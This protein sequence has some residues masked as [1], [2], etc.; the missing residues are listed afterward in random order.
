MNDRETHQLHRYRRGS[1]GSGRDD[2][3]L[4]GEP[5]HPP[6]DHLS[7]MTRGMARPPMSAGIFTEFMEQRGPGHTVGSENIY[8]EGLSGSTRQDIHEAHG[9]RSIVLHDPQRPAPPRNQLKAM[10]HPPVMLSLHPRSAVCRRLP[11]RNAAVCTD[12][13]PPVEGRPAE[14]RGKLRRSARPQASDLPS[15]AP[16]RTGSPIWL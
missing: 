6:Q 12:D 4:L 7:S 3:P 2:H 16:A 13:R 9:E 5:L 1:Q 8:Q 10:A 11:V 14:D 15:G